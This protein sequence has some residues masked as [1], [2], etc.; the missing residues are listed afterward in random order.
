MDLLNSS[1]RGVSSYAQALH[2]LPKSQVSSECRYHRFFGLVVKLSLR[3]LKFMGW[4]GR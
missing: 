2:N 1:L 4:R 3:Y